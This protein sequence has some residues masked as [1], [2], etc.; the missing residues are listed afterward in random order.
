MILN[1]AEPKAAAN[2]FINEYLGK[3]A[4]VPPSAD[5]FT[6]QRGVATHITLGPVGPSANTAIVQMVVTGDISRSMAK[7]LLDVVIRHSRRRGIV[8]NPIFVRRL[9]RLRGMKQV[10]DTG[11]IERLVEEIVAKHPDKVADVKANPKAIGWFVG[12]VMKASG[13]KANPQAVNELLKAKL[14]V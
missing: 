10:T 12:R 11:A 13:G 4:E 1:G 7:D 9:A 14:G 8:D 3:S 5:V 2:W 6:R